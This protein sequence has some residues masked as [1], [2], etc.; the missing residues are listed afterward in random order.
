MSHS[1]T[2]IYIK[3]KAGDIIA[4]YYKNGRKRKRHYRIWHMLQK[5]KTKAPGFTNSHEYLQMPKHLRLL[6]DKLCNHH[7][8][9]FINTLESFEH[10]PVKALKRF[11]YTLLQEQVTYEQLKQ[12]LKLE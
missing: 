3:N 12:H 11:V 7:T 1:K 6:H 2:T 5:I 9:F 10:E 4:K 8:H